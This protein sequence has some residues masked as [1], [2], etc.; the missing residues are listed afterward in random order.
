MSSRSNG[1][2]S[3][4]LPNLRMTAWSIVLLTLGCVF[5]CVCQ[6]V[7]CQ[8]ARPRPV[9]DSHTFFTGDTR[10]PLR[11]VTSG[12]DLCQ[13]T[14]TCTV[15]TL[16][17]LNTIR[18]NGMNAL[19]VGAEALY[20]SGPQDDPYGCVV[21]GHECNEEFLDQFVE[22]SA[23]AGIYLIIT[24]GGGNG[25]D[26]QAFSREEFECFNLKFWEHYAPRYS[27]C[28]H[29]L[30]EV[31]N[32]AHFTNPPIVAQPSPS[33]VFDLNAAAYQA[34]RI[35]SEEP[36]EPVAPDTPVL[37]FSYAALHDAAA[38]RQ[39]VRA[40]AQ[41]V[42]SPVRDDPCP[43]SFGGL[44]GGAGKPPNLSVDWSR[45]GVAFHGYRPTDTIH[46]LDT[47]RSDG[48][49]PTLHLMD[50]EEYEQALE[51]LRKPVRFDPRG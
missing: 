9:L 43:P 6:A 48:L 10:Q 40:F 25:A 11:G 16:Q 49:P 18:N 2:T 35:G 44:Q 46:T 42:Q 26:N 47:L 34:I 19:R 23:A 3:D 8:G 37:L 21:P 20:P 7:D 31:Q 41:E 28:T 27:H 45:T 5:P 51:E 30:Y 33:W 32:E 13:P 24:V 12:L 14:G 22:N 39:D 1:L 38:V 50:T 29:V 17:E 36:Y 4:R 15:P